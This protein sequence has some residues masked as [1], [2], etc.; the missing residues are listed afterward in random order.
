MI[1][2]AVDIG[3]NSTRL[4]I[5]EVGREIKRL[6]KET[7]I[8]RLGKMVD[9]DRV[10]SREGIER[11][12]D[13][14]LGYKKIAEGYGIRDI[15]AIATSAVRDAANRE[16]FIST[17]GDRTGIEVKVISGEEEAELGFIGA[18]SVLDEG[19]KVVCDI[20]GGSTELIYGEKRKI[21]MSDSIDVGAVRITERFFNTC[22]LE[23]GQ[24]RNAYSFIRNSLQKYTAGIKAEAGD[25]TLIGIGGTVTTLAAM[26]QEL[27]VYDIDRVHGYKLNKNSVDYLLQKLISVGLEDRRRMSGLQRERADII[28]AGALILKTVM[29]ELAR[30]FIMVSEHDNLDGLI[31]KD[32]GYS[33]I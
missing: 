18:S 6:E 30:D 17:V 5:A 29:E 9:K 10:L 7:T 14:L 11:T 8:T 19:Y 22:T 23:K 31:L 24:I 33:C 4:Y 12:V 28:P 2:A 21:H 16:E 15:V 3:T 27:A 20:G 1:K 26:D 13:V 25:F 32:A